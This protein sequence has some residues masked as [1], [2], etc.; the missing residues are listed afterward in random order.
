[1]HWNVLPNNT[2]LLSIIHV[3]V[4]VSTAYTARLVEGHLRVV[5]LGDA[6]A[7]KD[8]EYGLL[9]RWVP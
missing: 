4:H 2:S 3:Q 8:A 5:H 9:D 7:A 1:M 6:Q